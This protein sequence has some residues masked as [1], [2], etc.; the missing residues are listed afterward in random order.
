MG[1]SLSPNGFKTVIE[2]DVL[3]TYNMSAAAL[4]ALKAT[5]QAVV[6]N[7]TVPPQ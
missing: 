5:G 6:I 1:E 3:G 2:I 7:T 4:P